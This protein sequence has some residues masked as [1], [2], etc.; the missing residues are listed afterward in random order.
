MSAGGIVIQEKIEEGNNDLIIPLERPCDEGE[1]LV[2]DIPAS[3]SVL[4]AYA[5]SPDGKTWYKKTVNIPPKV[6]IPETQRN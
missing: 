5:I 2:S 1:V 6:E 4:T 3:G